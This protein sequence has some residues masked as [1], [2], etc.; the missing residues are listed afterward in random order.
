MGGSTE[1]RTRGRHLHRVFE[2]LPAVQSPLG[3]TIPIDC[4]A[5]LIGNKSFLIWPSVPLPL[6]REGIIMQTT[7]QAQFKRDV[8]AYGRER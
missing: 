7:G 6:P 3:P 8:F 5:R 1:R 2:I 4:L